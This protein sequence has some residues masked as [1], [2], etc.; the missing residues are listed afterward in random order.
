MPTV[1]E[2][3]TITWHAPY[4]FHV[5][6]STSTALT[7]IDATEVYRKLPP[8]AAAGR[9]GSALHMM[10]V[11]QGF[12]AKLLRNMDE[13]GQDPNAFKEQRLTWLCTLPRQ[14][15]RQ[16]LGPFGGTGATPL[17]ESTEI[18]DTEKIT[19]LDSPVS[20]KGLFSPAVDG[21]LSALLRHRRLCKLCVTSC[22][23][24]PVLR[25]LQVT[26]RPH[27]LSSLQSRHSLS[28]SRN[29]SQGLSC[30]WASAPGQAWRN[31]YISSA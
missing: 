2:E 1:H 6:S 12:Q 11:L 16:C 27:P 29:L 4:S 18:R 31:A 23:S 30:S 10:V 20:P 17:T 14:W 26:I 15:H 9:A 22:L 7:T 24:S 5:N 8:Y 25:L 21:L 13:S 3:L 28:P 19:F